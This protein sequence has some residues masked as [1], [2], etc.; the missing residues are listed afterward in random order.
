MLLFG[1]EHAASGVFTT[2]SVYLIGNLYNC[3]FSE[4]LWMGQETV[5]V[6]A[7]SGFIS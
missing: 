4:I 1:A 3:S 2:V 6:S 7:K 5:N